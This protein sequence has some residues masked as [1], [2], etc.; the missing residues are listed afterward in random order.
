MTIRDGMDRFGRKAI[1]AMHAP[2]PEDLPTA[3]SIR[4]QVGKSKRKQERLKQQKSA[5][6]QE[7][8]L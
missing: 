5:N 8:L 1:D 3:A 4:A 7:E 2:L 6:N